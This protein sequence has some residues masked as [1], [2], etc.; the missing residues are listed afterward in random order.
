MKE[1]QIFCFAIDLFRPC[2]SIQHGDDTVVITRKV[3]SQ[4][5]PCGRMHSVGS[6]CA[7][8]VNAFTHVCLMVISLTSCRCA[9]VIAVSH[10][11]YVT[12][13]Q[14]R[15]L[16]VINVHAFLPGNVSRCFPHC[17]YLCSVLGRCVYRRVKYVTSYISWLRSYEINI[18]KI[19]ESLLRRRIRNKSARTACV[20]MYNMK[21]V[22]IF[23]VKLKT[24]VS[25]FF[26]K[27]FMISL[28]IFD[29]SWSPSTMET[30]RKNVISRENC[31]VYAGEDFHL[32]ETAATDA[33]RVTARKNC[34]PCHVLED[35]GTLGHRLNTM[36]LW[37]PPPP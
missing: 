24:Y 13:I 34:V 21:Y 3:T 28:D 37:L 4:S 1:K 29:L 23:K 22:Q 7:S 12:Y 5:V 2:Y 16:V 35:S 6:F 25:Y 19:T 26:K 30:F 15:S 31:I 11:I 10:I 8:S 20:C 17:G 9:Y 32:H 18:Q 36:R 33:Q 27:L 14:L